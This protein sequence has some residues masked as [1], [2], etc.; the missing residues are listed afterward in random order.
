MGWKRISKEYASPLC[1]AVPLLIFA[2]RTQRG[3]KR[4]Q[5]AEA[6]EIALREVAL[7][8][9]PGHRPNLDTLERVANALLFSLPEFLKLAETVPLPADRSQTVCPSP[10]PLALPP[11]PKWALP[12]AAS[13]PTG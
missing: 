13:V 5:L 2:L 10:F 4:W 3:W 1:Y 6:A 8:E 12:T 9:T 11:L 7:L